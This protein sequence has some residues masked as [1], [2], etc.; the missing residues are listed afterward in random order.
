LS[1]GDDGSFGA[2]AAAPLLLLIGVSI[3][4]QFRNWKELNIQLCDKDLTLAIKRMF[5]SLIT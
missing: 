1:P 3:K 5:Y 4:K 2:S